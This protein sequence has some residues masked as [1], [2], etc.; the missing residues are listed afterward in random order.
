M[1]AG[2]IQSKSGDVCALGRFPIYLGFQIAI[3]T[4]SHFKEPEKG[5][6]SPQRLE[7]KHL[8]GLGAE[9]AGWVLCVPEN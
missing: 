6:F 2:G 1:V 9:R 3:E 4:S 8:R 5:I 7:K